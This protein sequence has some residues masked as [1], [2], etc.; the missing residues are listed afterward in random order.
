MATLKRHSR[1]DLSTLV[2]STRAN[3]TAML[4]GQAAGGVWSPAV[5]RLLTDSLDEGERHELKACRESLNRQAP[6]HEVIDAS[7]R[8]LSVLEEIE[9]RYRFERN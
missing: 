4:G 2:G 1:N 8:M 3:V 7:L 6:D 9:T 5:E